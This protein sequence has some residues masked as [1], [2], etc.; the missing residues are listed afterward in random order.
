[1]GLESTVAGAAI[2]AASKKAEMNQRLK[3][4]T[5]EQQSKRKNKQ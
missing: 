4:R 2:D 1:M 5:P 3:G